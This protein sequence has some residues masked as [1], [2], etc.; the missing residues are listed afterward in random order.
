[1]QIFKVDPENPQE[2]FI[3]K[4][5]KVL[6]V[7][8]LVVYPTETLYGLGA[9][10]MSAGSI[11]RVFETKGRFRKKPVSIMFRDVEQARKYAR[12]NDVAN[13]LADFLL[14]GPLTMVLPAKI[15]M[16]EMF[17]DEKIAVRVSTNKVVNAI[18]QKVKFPI[19]ATSANIS[20]KADP[21]SAQDAADQIGDKVDII[22]DAGSTGS[23]KPSTVIQI[24][25]DGVKIIR[26]GA[27]PKKRIISYI[28]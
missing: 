11:E 12:F 2:E 19:T 27:V 23:I 21:I 5:G 25:E 9:N 4:A 17:G 22:L 7:G 20:G 28:K 8:G 1:M 13:K 16:G 6:Q 10:I 26:E 14:P 18:M 3:E 15:P 24:D